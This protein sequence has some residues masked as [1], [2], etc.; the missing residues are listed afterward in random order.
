MSSPGAEERRGMRRSAIRAPDFF[1]KVPV[2]CNE[3]ARAVYPELGTQ[4][5]M[6]TFDYEKQ[7]VVPPHCLWVS[8]LLLISGCRVDAGLPRLH[9]A[10]RPA[11]NLLAMGEKAPGAW[12][13]PGADPLQDL[14]ACI[15]SLWA[16]GNG[17]GA[18]TACMSA[19]SISL[20]GAG[21]LFFGNVSKRGS[22]DGG[23]VA[24]S[25]TSTG[26]MVAFD[27][28]SGRSEGVPPRAPN[29]D[30][31]VTPMPETGDKV[32]DSCERPT[33]KVMFIP[34]P[35][36]WKGH[37]VGAGGTFKGARQPSFCR[38]IVTFSPAQKQ[39]R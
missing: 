18:A 3:R 38:K 37:A 32:A 39:V 11:G 31:K 17:T 15:A 2:R 30:G 5:S 36:P 25:D 7:P 20:S 22:T 24:S 33:A 1:K 8:G 23:D 16:G 19:G 35:Q 12:G 14:S 10:W 34:K 21:F 9:R 28:G 4:F 29:P 26:A 13:A 27:E 6:Q